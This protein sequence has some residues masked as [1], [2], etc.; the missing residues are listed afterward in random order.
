MKEKVIKILLISLFIFLIIG[1][2][3]FS[4]RYEEFSND[5]R[6]DNV[7]KINEKIT[8]EKDEYKFNVIYYCIEQLLTYIKDEKYDIALNL[9]DKEYISENGINSNNIKLLFNNVNDFTI[10]DE[11]KTENKTNSV[12]YVSSL[13]EQNKNLKSM[14]FIVYFDYNNRTYSVQPTSED[15]YN[16]AKKNKQNKVQSFIINPNEYN[17]Y[18]YNYDPEYIAKKYIKDFY[19]KSTYLPKEA[20]KILENSSVDYLKNKN[21]ISKD[22]VSEVLTI[23]KDINE[24]NITYNLQTIHTTYKIIVTN[25]M[26]YKIRI[27]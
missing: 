26:D 23:S 11:Y 17:I 9:L 3:Y 1:N 6:D 19:L 25:V 7:E 24:K 20:N 22:T 15:E 14:Y 10:L 21:M 8:K 27:E 16:L 4:I 18:K 12:Y 13:I 2:I 5:P